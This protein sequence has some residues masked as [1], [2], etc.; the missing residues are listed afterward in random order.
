MNKD[1]SAP[2]PVRIAF[3]HAGNDKNDLGIRS[4]RFI[5]WKSSLR[6]ASLSTGG[7]ESAKTRPASDF[8]EYGAIF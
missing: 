2:H 3:H 1:S 4:V 8:G 6:V 5:C 7:V